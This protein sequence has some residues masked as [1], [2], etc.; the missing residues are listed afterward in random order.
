MRKL[1]IL[2]FISLLFSCASMP[3]IDF[4]M[5]GEINWD[6]VGTEG[7][8]TLASNALGYFVG[9]SGSVDLENTI[10]MHYA[11]IKAG[12]IDLVALNEGLKYIS[13]GG[14]DPLLG[15]LLTN[16][17][18]IF[19]GVFVNGQLVQLDIPEEIWAIAEG[20]YNTGLLLGKMQLAWLDSHLY[21]GNEGGG[22][23]RR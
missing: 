17:I 12:R 8:V 18:S 7:A 3:D 6:D 5:P 9:K 1:L 23:A 19:G 15:L 16:A 22:Y 21:A 13:A 4:E 10:A 20:A 11:N 2:F 14:M